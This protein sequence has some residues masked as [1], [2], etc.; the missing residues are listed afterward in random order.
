MKLR[1][2]RTRWHW[3]MHLDS[4]AQNK[5]IPVQIMRLIHHSK[6][7]RPRVR[8][9]SAPT[10]MNIV[11][12]ADESTQLNMTMQNLDFHDR[13]SQIPDRDVSKTSVETPNDGGSDTFHP[14]CPNC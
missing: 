10:C 1:Y 12:K 9:I 11:K 13:L 14:I 7:R 2:W 4:V 8:Q 5:I 6:S 3:L